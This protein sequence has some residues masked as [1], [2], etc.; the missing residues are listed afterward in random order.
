MET[1][2]LDRPREHLLGIEER[3]NGP[4]VEEMLLTR[5]VKPQ[6]SNTEDNDIVRRSLRRLF[7]KISIIFRKSP[8]APRTTTENIP[9]EQANKDG[10]SSQKPNPVQ[11]GNSKSVSIPVE[12]FTRL[13]LALVSCSLLI[14]PLAILSFQSKRTA[15]LVT[16]AVSTVVFSLLVS[17]VSKSSNSEIMAAAAGY[18]AVLV[19][20][21]AVAPQSY[22]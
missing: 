14:A 1:I 12:F 15:H 13:I 11:I 16:V 8:Q 7:V 3:Y 20:F 19:V 4:F 18:T 21:V 22:T 17:L 9:A 6:S 2:L 5:V 10:Q